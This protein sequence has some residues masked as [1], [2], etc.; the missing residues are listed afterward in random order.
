[1]RS[2]LITIGI[3]LLISCNEENEMGVSGEP[4]NTKEYL[5]KLK[6]H[7][8][9]ADL[10]YRIVSNP[11]QWDEKV[12]LVLYLNDRVAYTGGYKE[13][14]VLKTERIEADG[15]VHMRMEI[16]KENTLYV[17]ENKSIFLWDEGYKYVY[18][19]IFPDNPSTDNIHFFPQKTDII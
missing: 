9:S 16:I 4:I 14:G 19:G 3:A 18:I 1:M 7:S 5:G 11:Y 2:I 12:H 10:L 8:N 13:A 17:F 15:V 6:T